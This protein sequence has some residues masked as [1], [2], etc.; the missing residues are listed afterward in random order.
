MQ[1]EQRML[2]EL[3]RKKPGEGEGEGET[4]DNVAGMG[5]AE[6]QGNKDV[7]DQIEDEEQLLGLQ[8]EEQK[9]PEEAKSQKSQKGCFAIACEAKGA[10]W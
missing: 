4:D 7:S 6:G 8:G 1:R 2:E 9:E 3:S 5:M 10:P